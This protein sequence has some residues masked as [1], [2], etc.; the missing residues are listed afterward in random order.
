VV[1]YP[2]LSPHSDASYETLKVMAHF[3]PVSFEIQHV[4]SSRKSS[5]GK[6]KDEGR[7]ELI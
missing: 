4:L 5:S 1:F 6:E 3:H 7:G 2:S